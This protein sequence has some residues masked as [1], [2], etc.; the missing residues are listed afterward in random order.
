MGIPH[1]KTWSIRAKSATGR[2][3]SEIEI[4]APTKILARLNLRHEQPKWLVW[5]IQAPIVT[6]VTFSAKR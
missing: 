6:R 2:T 3:V 1:V 5:A 4:S